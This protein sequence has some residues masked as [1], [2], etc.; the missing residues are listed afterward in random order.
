MI[1]RMAKLRS[2]FRV[3]R[4]SGTDS[5]YELS[6]KFQSLEDL[7]TADQEL[8][9][10]LG[11]ER[12]DL[13]PLVGIQ[14]REAG[15]TT[16]GEPKWIDDPHDIEQGQM[17]NP[18]WLKLHGLT[19]RE[20]TAPEQ[21]TAP[22]AELLRGWKRYEKLRKLTPAAFNR[23]HIVNVTGGHSF[24]DLVDALPE[25][26]TPVPEQSAKGLTMGGEAQ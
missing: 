23:L 7:N 11:R 5:L 16:S 19:L 1:D 10:A 13:G 25:P 12:I 2:G 6:I 14:S 22:N 9:D 15:P 18:A 26:S 17:L 20:A 4:A 3:T 24:D 21:S 8:R